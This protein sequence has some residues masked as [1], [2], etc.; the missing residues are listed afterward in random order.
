MKYKILKFNKFI[1]FKFY[2]YHQLANIYVKKAFTIIWN[3][4]E[5]KI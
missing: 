4:S 5:T 2:N 3:T 1:D